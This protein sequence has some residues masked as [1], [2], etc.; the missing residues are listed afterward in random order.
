MHIIREI[1][2]D[3]EDFEFLTAQ[4]VSVLVPYSISTLHE[5]AQRREL[6]LPSYGPPHV[7]LGPRRR[8]WLRR[9]VVAWIEGCH[10]SGQR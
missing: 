2:S 6:G 10:V 3:A 1:S 7:Q 8:R 9:D 5:Y 4:Q